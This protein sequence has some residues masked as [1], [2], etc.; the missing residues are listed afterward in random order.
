MG[1]RL[2][3]FVAWLGAA[4]VAT[5]LLIGAP[6]LLL[7]A[8]DGW[9]GPTAVPTAEQVG[10]FFTTRLSDEHLIAVFVIVG[11]LLWA[12]FVFVFVIE[13][14]SQLRNRES[15]ELHSAAITQRAARFIVTGLFRLGAT[16]TAIL[17]VVG[18]GASAGAVVM[19]SSQAGAQEL[20]EGV[21]FD[22]DPESDTTTTTLFGS[23]DGS[24]STIVMADPSVSPRDGKI[25]YL[26]VED[27][28][29]WDI[30]E[31]HTGD[32][33]RWREVFDA[34]K[35]FTQ[36]GADDRVLEQ[37][38]LINPGM[39]LLLP[40]DAVDVPA[41]DEALVEAV[42]GPSTTTVTPGRVGVGA[43]GSAPEQTPQ[44]RLETKEA[45]AEAQEGG[46]ATYEDQIGAQSV[47]P[48]TVVEAPADSV[49]PPTSM[50]A[51]VVE[52]AF[53]P[54]A[55]RETVDASV[56]AVGLTPSTA[57]VGFG[58]GGV[59]FATFMAMRL[60]K[61]KRWTRASRR[62]GEVLAPLD[63]DS[64]ELERETI[65]AA[66]FEQ[67]EFYGRAW[68]SL[69]SR[70][71]GL[72]ETCQPLLAIRHG[73]ELQVLMS[74]PIS[75]APHPWVCASVEDD[76][77]VWTL[78][79]DTG[80]MHLL[81]D[82]LGGAGLPLMVNVGEN[83][84]VNLEATGPF[85]VS[86]DP[87]RAVG[88]ARSAMWEV[89]VSPWVDGVDIRMTEAAAERMGL[90]GGEVAV[91]L[92]QD[93]T[94]TTTLVAAT[95]EGHGIANIHVARAARG[96]ESFP[97]LV[98]ADASDE[99]ALQGVLLAARELR[100]PIGVLVLDGRSDSYVAEVDGVGNLTLSPSGLRARA[101]F[102]EV[103]RGAMFHE[104]ERQRSLLRS[105]VGS[106]PV[107][108]EVSAVH[109]PE[110]AEVSVLAG[111]V[112][113]DGDASGS[114]HADVDASLEPVASPSIHADTEFPAPPTQV[115]VSAQDDVESPS[116]AVSADPTDGDDVAATAVDDELVVDDSPT[117]V[118]SGAQQ[119]VSSADDYLIDDAGQ[120]SAEEAE[121]DLAVLRAVPVTSD[122]DS[123]M[124]VQHVPSADEYEAVGTGG[125]IDLRESAPLQVEQGTLFV[126]VLG[127]PEI[128]G[129]TLTNVS[130]TVLSFMAFL[131]LEGEQN[132]DAL[133]EAMFKKGAGVPDSTWRSLTKRVREQI[134]V[135][136]YPK[137]I[138]QNVYQVLSTV[139]DFGMMMSKLAAA[140]GI[141]DADERLDEMAE[142]L[143]LIG[144]EP[145]GSGRLDDCWDWIDKLAS[146][147]RLCL[148][149]AVNDAVTK[150]VTLAM[151][152]GRREDA[153]EIIAKGQ[154]ANPHGEW[155]TTTQVQ[156]LIELD[157]RNSAQT[158][159]EKYEAHWR[160]V[161]A[162]EPSGGPRE[163]FER[164][165][166]AS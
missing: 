52:Q 147:P 6:L 42:Y 136:N 37:P 158:V 134:P 110:L 98:I 97:T 154:L 32:P 108:R 107:V 73:D 123:D 96:A 22:T 100:L 128:I 87:H 137:L 164:R 72:E 11:W 135:A 142:A 55:E 160:D 119:P 113:V 10:E 78:P 155:L 28:T 86:G 99:P 148:E 43:V 92:D 50:P 79:I 163:M 63:E 130:E 19:M 80:T 44:E 18:P 95:M 1:K 39:V 38:R 150:A 45:L 144:G 118:N 141:E 27:D 61:S 33:Q 161:F 65:E 102:A 82:D 2:M 5:G 146:Q 132:R 140:E 29:L 53:N 62:P 81:P 103:D 26:V 83:V 151:D 9:P 35:G 47:E 162:M 85:G 90:D 117:V 166:A 74:E 3:D 67:A 51:A 20:P 152:L 105:V 30:S 21:T 120:D 4:I 84:F 25:P 106:E 59:L 24:S 139:T 16:S 71:M 127:T 7:A 68:H 8:G 69:A 122:A 143:T 60:A 12:H 58:A 34:S 89:A 17:G 124:T 115:R 48:E 126:R 121:D 153:L 57:A 76:R 46:G 131:A 56:P 49:A 54:E 88:L 111:A 125:V 133:K 145:F 40:G 15:K 156:L 114:V 112:V 23:D 41:V 77:A 64:A 94:A 129:E 165:R 149:A 13:F 138:D 104:L 66:D 109:G 75:D 116:D 157:R 159:V 14:V 91:A 101:S 93:V 31:R 36:P 70:K